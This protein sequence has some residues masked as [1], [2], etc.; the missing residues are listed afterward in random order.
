MKRNQRWLLAAFIVLMLIV[1]GWRSISEV[2]TEYLWYSDLGFESVLWN[3]LGARAVVGLSAAVFAFA[4]IGV[5]LALT[6]K[7]SGKLSPT[8]AMVVAAVGAVVAFI[9]T[10]GRWMEYQQFLHATDFGVI[11][12]LFGKDVSFFVFKLP[13]LRHALG[14]MGTIALATGIAV[15]VV[16]F[17]SG[18]LVSIGRE[19]VEL[20][21]EPIGLNPLRPEG[22]R[23]RG[24]LIV[25]RANPGAKLHVCIM[26]AILMLLVAAAQMLSAWSLAYSTRGVVAGPSYA[27]VR[28]AL[29]AL[30]IM[31]VLWIVGSLVVIWSGVTRRPIRTVGM[32]II[33]PAVLIGLSV[34][35]V[36]FVPDLIQRMYVTPN[37]LAAESPYIKNNIEF[38]TKAFGLESIEEREYRVR[39]GIT[40][41]QLKK[42]DATLSNVRLWDW[43]PLL[44]AFEQLQEM[45]L[46]YRFGDI[47]IDRYEINGEQ[48][49]V[50]VAAREID[51]DR[52]PVQAQTWVNR[53]LKYTHGY[54]VCGSPVNVIGTDGLP[55][56]VV[57]DIPLEAPESMR[58]DV[59]QIYFGELTTDWVVA[60]T[61]AE[62][63]DY[64]LGESN[65]YNRYD[66]DSGVRMGGLLT[67]AM[68][69]AKF[70]DV[71]LL[72]SQDITR[73][74]RMLYARD[75]WTRVRRIAPFLQ[76]DRDPYIAIVDGRLVWMIN[77]MT[78]SNMYPFAQPY[79]GGLNYI[80]NSVK[81][82]VDA[83]TG[84]V[85]FY[86][87]DDTDPI[88]A[89]YGKVFPG[90]F[91][92]ASEMTEGERRHSRYPEDLF[93]IQSRMYATYH[94]S[95]PDVFY[96][97]EDVWGLPREIYGGQQSEVSP[98]YVN[99]TLPGEDELSFV[100]FTPF[101][102]SKK[103]NMVAWLAVSSEMDQYGRMV[104]F[105]FGKQR[106]VF[107]PMQ[108][109][110]QIDQDADI[111]RLLSLWNQSGSR[112]VRGNLL[113]YPIDGGILY[114]EPL[115]LAAQTSQL[116]QLKRVVVSDGARVEIGENLEAALAALTGGA[117]KPSAG[118]SADISGYG[119]QVQNTGSES[120]TAA[121]ALELYRQSQER[122][123]QGDFQG[124]GALQEELEALLRQLA[125][126]NASE[127]GSL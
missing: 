26:I 29:P 109:E 64:P 10:Q 62:E 120:V 53:R 35:A 42:A 24:K 52:L 116:P 78:V 101:T 7:S 12:P 88:A 22:R 37:E 39:E 83:Y 122:L 20:D 27:D 96:N 40:G 89:T 4:F 97:N 23:R 49:Q 15:F 50:M 126:Q 92:P 17:L 124:F 54:G 113:V 18:S 87:V 71:R 30:K 59:P 84:K 114:V 67:R 123:R 119:S 38:T 25:E 69:A 58:V 11:T 91:K 76:Y 100:L 107:G 6:K 31:S 43:D 21:A 117:G 36:G 90:L 73:D 9:A 57:R 93:K 85:N 103:D 106:V 51:L 115:F 98:Y 28:G 3:R 41:A 125:G 19:Q 44:K 55:T 112:V 77:A 127:G 108:I 65:Q 72:L 61:K 48:T 33:T 32:S 102:P 104:A 118:S 82:T 79:G 13:L 121:R 86:I 46:Y 47:D 105:N 5:N 34:L 8:T 94:V 80:R 70:S 14:F 60:N 66:A 74:S 95:D 56:F 2:V 75:I 111:S 110:A 63:F 16:Y 1:V 81:V 68:F 99:M 45:R